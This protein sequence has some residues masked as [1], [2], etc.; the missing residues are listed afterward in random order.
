ML[1]TGQDVTNFGGAP[2]S[3]VDGAWRHN[4]GGFKGPAA[5]AQVELP[6]DVTRIGA[7]VKFAA[8]AEKSGS[9]ALVVPSASWASDEAWRSGVHFVVKGDGEWR[10]SPYSNGKEGKPYDQG[11]AP[12]FLDGREYRFDILVNRAAGT[13]TVVLPDGSHHPVK[14]TLIKADSSRFAIFELYERDK[15]AKPAVIT[16]MWASSK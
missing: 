6:K 12:S 4:V 10:I 15:T 7:A 9:V 13:A 2:G 14:S 1:D 3:V 16:E 11:F 5:Y 8:R